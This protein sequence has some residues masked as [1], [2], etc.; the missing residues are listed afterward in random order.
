[1]RILKTVREPGLEGLVEAIILQ[2]CSDY[3]SL[4]LY[5]CVTHGSPAVNTVEC[6][7]FFRSEWFAKMVENI[8][9]LTGEDVIAELQDIAERCRH[10]RYDY[11]RRGHRYVVFDKVTGE[12][13]TSHTWAE[14][15]AADAARRNHITVWQFAMA[16]HGPPLTGSFSLRKKPKMNTKRR[17]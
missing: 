11:K 13:L 7:N 10:Y 9:G 3:L 1:M 5:G 17:K 8:D 12:G 6:E 14:P 16:R 15:A 4:L 2:A